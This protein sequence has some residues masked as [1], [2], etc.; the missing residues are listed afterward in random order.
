MFEALTGSLPFRGDTIAD[1]VSKII[2]R[3][4]DWS[5]LPVETPA[6]IVRQLHRCLEKE[7]QRRPGS[8]GELARTVHL[9]LRSRM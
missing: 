6:E 2:E 1:T 8:M 5:K 9:F 4:P 7:P 3:D